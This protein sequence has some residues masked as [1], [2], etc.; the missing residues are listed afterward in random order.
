MTA[1]S[2]ANRDA[3]LLAR[4][5]LVEVRSAAEIAA[6]LDAG[7]RHDGL[8]F[9]PEMSAYIGQRYRVYRR[10][11]K[12]C[13]EGFGMRAMSNTVFLTDVRCGGGA[14]DGCERGCLIF[15]KEAWLRP[16]AEDEPVAAFSTTSAKPLECA[17]REG[18]RYICQSTELSAATRDLSMFNVAH[19]LREV[20][21]GELSIPRLLR[22]IGR[23]LQNRFRAM[24]G[25][26]PIG[27]ILGSGSQS[28]HARGDLGLREGEWVE[29]KSPDEIRATV[30]PAGKNRGLYF[31][32]D[33]LV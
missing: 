31:E 12:T 27:A 16:V 18:D 9:M 28:G 25:G 10:A 21:V 23:A 7:G 14:H 1:K 26:P 19:Y 15:W 30:G 11:E 6:T 2:A 17:P 24:V 3:I 5:Q 20:R 13:V 4:G 8:P 32:P 29:V 33:M 22:I